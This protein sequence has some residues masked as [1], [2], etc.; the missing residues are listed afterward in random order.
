MQH[1]SETIL[2]GLMSVS[3]N[4]GLYSNLKPARFRCVHSL[5][6]SEPDLQTFGRDNEKSLYYFEI[7]RTAGF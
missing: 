3:D 7:P 4:G 1:F 2:C 5:F 6:C